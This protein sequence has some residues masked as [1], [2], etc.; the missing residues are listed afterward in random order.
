LRG[1]QKDA[2]DAVIAA[3][4][5]ATLKMPTGGGKTE[6]ALEA[7]RRYGGRALWL[8]HRTE[9]LDQTA[10]RCEKRLG[11]RPTTVT[12]GQYGNDDARLTV[13]MVQTL[14]ASASPDFFSGFN[15]LVLDEAHHASSTTWYEVALQCTGARLRLG[16]SGTPRTRDPVRDLRLEGITGPTVE[17]A[18][19]AALVEA[20]YLAR[21]LVRL[22]RPDPVSY[23]DWR[24]VRDAVCPGWRDNPRRLTPLG[25]RMYALAYQRGV[26]ENRV[27]NGRLLA[28]AR[29][30][31]EA[32][33]RVLVLAVRVP[34]A[35]ALAKAL[36]NPTPQAPGAS[37]ARL[38]ATGNGVP[39]VDVLYGALGPVARRAA[40]EAFRASPG[41]C[42]LVATQSL[43]GEGMD[44][45]EVDALVL[46]GGGESDIALTQA[47]GRA[48]RPRPGKSVAMIYDCAD[49][50][51][52][53]Q[54]RDYLA[55]HFAAR[56]ATYKSLGFEVE[57]SV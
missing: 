22:L 9:L 21:P 36:Q 7:L 6:C 35:Q 4:H 54:S 13:A 33:E 55:S 5:R 50:R 51:E 19:S 37:R 16:L 41:G 43:F 29:R 20:G 47:C 31:A 45:P 14:A 10:E 1:Y 27:R 2:V 34:H 32:G 17:A 52:P 42:V 3:G 49:G 12:A 39:R 23:P 28:A 40:L 8:T 15:A 44:V 30:H 18:E 38:Q 57:E 53:G 56:M 48:L 24:E 46:A 25:A 26:L 11:F